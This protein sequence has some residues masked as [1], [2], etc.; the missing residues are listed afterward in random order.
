MKTNWFSGENQRL[1]EKKN[2]SQGRLFKKKDQHRW[3]IC[4]KRPTTIYDSIIE[5]KLSS[6]VEMEQIPRYH[7]ATNASAEQNS[8]VHLIDW[9]MDWL[10]RK[11]KRRTRKETVKLKYKH[12]PSLL[13]ASSFS[14]RPP[15]NPPFTSAH[16]LPFCLSPPV[17][18]GDRKQSRGMKRKKKSSADVYSFA[19]IYLFFRGVPIPPETCLSRVSEHD[20]SHVCKGRI[21]DAGANCMS[22]GYW[23]SFVSWRSASSVMKTCFAK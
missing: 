21:A 19:A 12:G 1:K 7:K 11:R 23:K 3:M 2:I 16:Y 18:K 13:F 8:F 22:S 5:K 4:K 6:T 17:K 20:F 14:V 15:K 9:L 10:I